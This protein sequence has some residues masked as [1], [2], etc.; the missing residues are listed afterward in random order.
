MVVSQDVLGFDQWNLQRTRDRFIAAT[1]KHGQE[2]NFAFR[3]FFWMALFSGILR[4]QTHR[5]CELDVDV[6]PTVVSGNHVRVAR[7]ASS[8]TH[9]LRRVINVSEGFSLFW[10]NQRPEPFRESENESAFVTV[11]RGLIPASRAG[12]RIEVGT[13]ASIGEDG[14]S[15]SVEFLNGLPSMIQIVQLGVGVA[16]RIESRFVGFWQSGSSLR[17]PNIVSIQKRG[18]LGKGKNVATIDI[19]F[20]VCFVD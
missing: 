13:A 15:R 8:N 2:A 5:F 17:P 10:F 20:G 16:H 18:E 4:N 9:L 12:E 6:R 14:Q 3:A 19:V 1:V 11:L 7:P